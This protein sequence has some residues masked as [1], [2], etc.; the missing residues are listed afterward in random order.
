MK[1]W[2]D[3]KEHRASLMTEKEL[4]N[5]EI[6]EEVKGLIGTI[7]K[8]RHELGIS[9]RKLAVLCHLPHSSITR[10]ESFQSIPRVDTIIKIMRA[11]DLK[12]QLSSIQKEN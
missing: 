4:I 12:L 3:Y 5:S 9:Q 8:K 7:I 2:E 10:I 11:L 1:T 6:I